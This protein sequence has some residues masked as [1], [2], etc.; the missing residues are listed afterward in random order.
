MFENLQIYKS[1]FQ[2]LMAEHGKEV[3]DEHASKYKHKPL[4][5]YL[6]FQGVDVILR[7]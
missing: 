6:P 2:Y 3:I 4:F 1:T 5:L 7:H